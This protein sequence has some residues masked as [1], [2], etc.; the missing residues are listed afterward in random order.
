MIQN[1]LERN[2]AVEL[3][4]GAKVESLLIE[5]NT[6]PDFLPL[7][8]DKLKDFIHARKFTGK[9]FQGSKITLA[10]K[11]LNKTVYRAQTA[12]EIERDCNEEN[13]CLVWM[14]WQLRNE[15]LVLKLPDVPTMN[16]NLATPEFAVTYAGRLSEKCP[17]EYLKSDVWVRTVQSTVKGVNFGSVNDRMV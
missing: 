4:L 1:R 2:K 6:I 10:G 7:T 11:K 8:T 12:E 3:I 9:T 15:K 5:D 16:T 17:S 13:P 14:A